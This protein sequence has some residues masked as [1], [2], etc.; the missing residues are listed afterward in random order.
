MRPVFEKNLLVRSNETGSKVNIQS[1]LELRAQGKVVLEIELVEV[2]HINT[3]LDRI[4]AGKDGKASCKS[5]ELFLPNT[6]H[7]L[8]TASSRKYTGVWG[9]LVSAHIFQKLIYSRYPQYPL[10]RSGN[11]LSSFQNP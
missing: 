10:L 6:S 8:E 5:S 11:A 2:N 7:F 1:A 4:K 9:A 3:A